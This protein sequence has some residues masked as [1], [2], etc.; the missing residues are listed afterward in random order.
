[1]E[2]Y[3]ILKASRDLQKV[4][5]C[6]WREALGEPTDDMPDDVGCDFALH[7]DIWSLDD[8]KL[9]DCFSLFPSGLNMLE[10]AQTLRR[11]TFKNEKVDDSVLLESIQDT[12]RLVKSV[13]AKTHEKGAIDVDEKKI[14]CTKRTVYRGD[15]DLR[16]AVFKNASPLTYPLTDIFMSVFEKHLGEVGLALLEFLNEPLYRIANT[17]IISD[18]ILWL[19]VKDEYGEDP[20]EPVIELYKKGAQSGWNINENEMFVYTCVV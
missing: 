12:N 8:E 18:S 11:I 13:L 17:Y 9:R 15:S 5:Q 2:R 3:K 19:A 16:L 6:Q 20:F 7:F 10:R 14:L 1:M 4:W